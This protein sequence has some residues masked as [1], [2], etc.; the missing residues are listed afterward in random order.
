MKL[1]F[2]VSNFCWKWP[3][4]FGLWDAE[5]ELFIFSSLLEAVEWGLMD[6][7]RKTFIP[8]CTEFASG[9]NWT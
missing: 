2:H 4:R 1:L 6:G 5:G 7:A 8:V 9:L 3:E